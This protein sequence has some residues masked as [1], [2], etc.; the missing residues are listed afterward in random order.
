MR[1][2]LTRRETGS[3]K[4]YARSVYPVGDARSTADNNAPLFPNGTPDSFSVRED[5]A[6]GTVVGT[7]RGS[8]VDSSDVLSHR[9]T[10][11]G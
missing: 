7:V 10:G 1:R 3:D 6:V 4:A 5:A 9:L 11:T 8:D 2:T